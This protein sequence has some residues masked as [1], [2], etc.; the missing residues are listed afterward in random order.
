MKGSMLTVKY[1][2]FGLISKDSTN[3]WHGLGHVT[4]KIL[5]IPSNTSPKPLKLETSNFG[6]LLGKSSGWKII[7]PDR[8]AAYVAWPFK[9]W[10]TYANT[11]LQKLNFPQNRQTF[12]CENGRGLGDVTLLI[13]GIPL[14]MSPELVQRTTS[15]Q[16]DLSRQ[17][18]LNLFR[19][20]L[21]KN[22]VLSQR[23]C[24]IPQLF[25]SV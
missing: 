8:G 1:N 24:A 6:I 17:F 12:F 20:N 11:Y 23:N 2:N 16:T 5:G 10:H 14:H 9:I 25:F 15:R 13:F 19:S 22:A 18:L 21:N 4:P 3:M 7:F